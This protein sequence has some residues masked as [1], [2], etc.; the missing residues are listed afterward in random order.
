M[1][2]KISFL[3]LADIFQILGGNN[4]SGILHLTSTYAPHPG[5]IFFLNG[6]PINASNGP[7]KGIEA[8]YSL[9]GWM[10]GDFEFQLDDVSV[11]HVVKQNRME[12]VLDALR[13]LDDGEIK[14]VAPPSFEDPGVE[15]S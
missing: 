11:E 12:I 9:F 13:L 8:I 7:L 4:S 6:D 5:K 1:T 15:E 10:D 3:G 2:G 14:R